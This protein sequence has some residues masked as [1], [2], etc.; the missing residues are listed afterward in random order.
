MES[1]LKGFD[2]RYLIQMVFKM[3]DDF[4]ISVMTQEVSAMASTGLTLERDKDK[5]DALK[6]VFLSCKYDG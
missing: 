2:L 1:N 3:F 5:L 6:K 4:V